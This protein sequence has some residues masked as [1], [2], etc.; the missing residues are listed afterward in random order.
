MHFTMLYGNYCYII[1]ENFP[2][3]FSPCR[4]RTDRNFKLSSKFSRKKS[5][6]IREFAFLIGSLG[7][8]C[9]ATKYG[10]AHLKDFQRS[11]YKALRD[12]GNDFEKYM[13]LPSSL[14][15]DFAWWKASIV[16]TKRE[17][18]NKNIYIIYYIKI[19]YIYILY[20]I[21]IIYN[22]YLYYFKYLYFN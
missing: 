1:I 15:N 5:C 16:G 22:I 11:R 2:Q 21:M 19:I 3:K 9:Q 8:F 10:W 14:K 17:I 4:D 20:Y 7:S 13:R 12:N 6:K 18:K